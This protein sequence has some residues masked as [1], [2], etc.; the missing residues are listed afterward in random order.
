M[1]GSVGIFLR[2]DDPD[3][4]VDE[5]DQAIHLEPVRDI[6]GV[7]VGEIEQDQAVELALAAGVE[8][9]LASELVTP[10]DTE[11]VQQW[12]RALRA[13]H[14]GK[15]MGSRGAAYSGS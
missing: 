10:R 15:R 3:E 5:L 9:G 1:E 8:D 4:E 11:P 2:I 14:A 12:L 6:G 13:P 7:L